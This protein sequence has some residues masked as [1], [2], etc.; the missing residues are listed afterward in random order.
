MTRATSERAYGPA[1]GEPPVLVDPRRWGGV[2]GLVGGLVFVLTSSAAFGAGVQ[3]PALVAGAGLALAALFGHYGRP[4]AL[5]PAVRPD[6]RALA[7]YGACVVGELALIVLGTAVLLGAGRTD[8]RPALIAAVV[9]LHFLPMARAFGERM[10]LLLGGLVSVAGATGLVAGAA[11]VP[12]AGDGAALA[13]G[14][15]LLGVVTAYAWGWFAP[16]G[17]RP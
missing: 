2:L 3:V 17:P 7:L 8:L 14:L 6:R 4:V 9:G 5:G 15:V 12:R 10:F 11:G 13:A 1:V 16:A